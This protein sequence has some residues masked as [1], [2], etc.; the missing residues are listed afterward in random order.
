MRPSS[1]RKSDEAETTVI[2]CVQIAA[3]L[4]S[5]VFC[6][7]SAHNAAPL[8]VA[9]ILIYT[10][11]S[12][13]ILDFSDEG[14]YY[15]S[16]W[17]A[18][19]QY[20]DLPV[21]NLLMN[22]GKILGL[23]YLITSE[24][25]I[26]EFRL[27]SLS[28]WYLVH[29]AFFSSIRNSL[30]LNLSSFWIHVLATLSVYVF[31]I[32]SLSYQNMPYL[33]ALL[34][35]AIC[36]QITNVKKT[37]LATILSFLLPLSVIAGIVAYSPFLVIAPLFLYA[38]YW[39][40]RS[41]PGFSRTAFWSGVAIGMFMLALVFHFD[42]LR[43]YESTFAFFNSEVEYTNSLRM[44][45]KISGLARVLGRDVLA[46]TVIVLLAIGIKR[47]T[48]HQRSA[49]MRSLLVLYTVAVTVYFVTTTFQTE[50]VASCDA[51]VIFLIDV[52]F[53]GLPLL[54]FFVFTEKQNLIAVRAIGVLLGLYLATGLFIGTLSNAPYQYNLKFMSPAL[55]GALLLLL[56][57]VGFREGAP[58]RIVGWAL[59]ALLFLTSLEATLLS[60]YGAVN[61]PPPRFGPQQHRS[62]DQICGASMATPRAR[63]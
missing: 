35:I 6:C 13:R 61:R 60:N 32:P 25:T 37:W 18:Y 3:V 57:G 31:L 36:L 54:A 33:F 52:T 58:Y 43:N 51:T 17:L 29:F 22:F 59:V 30:Q 4:R 63:A 24:P 49:I 50:C 48:G 8:G 15:T 53:A 46:G 28:A 16:A 23:P 45:E 38:T 26:L 1:H 20:G 9:L 40:A 19:S 55:L 56:L 21:N 62:R 44:L 39:Q 10:V 27:L 11:C 41:W 14:F 42:T 7:S 5:S 12:R 34:G 2:R 47:V